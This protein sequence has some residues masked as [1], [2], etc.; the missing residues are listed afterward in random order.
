MTISVITTW[1]GTPAALMLLTEA[2][3]NA[4]TLHVSLGAKNPRLLE[5]IAGGD[6]TRRH[7]VVDFDSLEA[8][9]SYSAGVQASEWWSTTQKAVA[10]AHPNLRLL[11]QAVMTNAIA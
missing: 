4:A 7:Y 9:A 1:E 8:W 11:G 3:R 6:V 2:S 5:P 10:D